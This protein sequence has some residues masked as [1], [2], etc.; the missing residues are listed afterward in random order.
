MATSDGKRSA[1]GER[2]ERAVDR[3]PLPAGV[4][5]TSGPVLLLQLLF[6]VGPL[7]IMVTIATME[8]ENLVLIPDYSLD[9]FVEVFTGF[10]PRT[11]F[12]NTVL[13]SVL[14]TLSAIVIAYP[15]AYFIARRGGSHKNQLLIL[16]MI[17]WWT[18]FI[19]RVY[20]WRLILGSRGVVNSALIYAGFI[21]Q[22]I[23]WLLNTKFSIWLGLTYLWLPFMILPL[24]TSL[25]KMDQSL[26]D[27][28]YDLGASRWVVF[29][30]IILPLSFSGLVGGTMFVFIFSMG[31]YIVP[32]MLGGG[33]TFVGPL[34]DYQFGFG[35]DWPMG[36]AIASV[37]MLIVMVVL[38][39]LMRHVEIEEMI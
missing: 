6:F 5:V 34:I 4:V 13:I 29:R 7:F 26:I 24:Y 33:T 31:S 15:I 2:F 32:S 38:R 18:N 9:N 17:P 19:V 10:V 25:E 30:R 16:V 23:D 28:A 14:T 1:L 12:T 3:S 39:A 27:A 21:D 36:A 35:G 37:L 11:A 20:G 22:P 8:M